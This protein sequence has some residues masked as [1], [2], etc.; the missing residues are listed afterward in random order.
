MNGHSLIEVF[1]AMPYWK[2]FGNLG[3]MRDNKKSHFFFL[4][5]CL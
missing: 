3:G 4:A 1:Q 2:L 5:C